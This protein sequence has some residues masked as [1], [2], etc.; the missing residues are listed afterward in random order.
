MI[1]HTPMFCIGVVNFGDIAIGDVHAE[2]QQL[3]TIHPPLMEATRK[4]YEK[5]SG[6]AISLERIKVYAWI[7]ELSDLVEFKKRPESRGFQKSM[8]RLKKW[9]QIESQ[10]I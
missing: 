5:I 3:Y 8:R 7:N 1:P 4:V 10:K 2:F 9:I 6:I